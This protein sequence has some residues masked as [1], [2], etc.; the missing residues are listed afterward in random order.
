MRPAY[1]LRGKKEL[2]EV[3]LFCPV[4]KPDLSHACSFAAS[5]TG[6]FG[7]SHNEETKLGGGRAACPWGEAGLE[8]GFV[9]ETGWTGL[10]WTVVV[11]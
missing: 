10:M 8:Q 1:V 6:L 4:T 2:R 11:C 3:Y 7:P 5:E 9:P